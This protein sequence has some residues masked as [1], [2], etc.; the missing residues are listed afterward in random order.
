MIGRPEREPRTLRFFVTCFANIAS[1]P[2][3]YK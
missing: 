3:R 1:L 2:I